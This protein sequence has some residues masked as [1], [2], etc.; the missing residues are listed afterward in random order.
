MSRESLF[1]LTRCHKPC[2]VPNTVG[3]FH[4]LKSST[5]SL[6]LVIQDTF[7]ALLRV[8]GYNVWFLA[9]SS[10]RL[11]RLTTKRSHLLCWMSCSNFVGPRY[12][13]ENINATTICQ[14][15]SFFLVSRLPRSKGNGCSSEP[16]SV[17]SAYILSKLTQALPR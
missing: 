1:F 11:D 2:T 17:F 10:S 9:E 3:M 14:E 12:G 7:F 8:Q 15:G 6:A 16:A 4:D 5:L 13:H